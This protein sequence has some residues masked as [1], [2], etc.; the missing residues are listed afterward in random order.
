[1]KQTIL[2]EKHLQNQEKHLPRA[3]RLHEGFRQSMARSTIWATMKKFKINGKLIETIQSLYENAMSAVLVQGATGEWFHTSVGVRQGCLL[4]PNPFNSFLEDT[5][6]HALAALEV[7]RKQVSLCRFADEIDGI[8]GEEDEVTKLVH[9]LDTAPT[10][11]GME[12]NAEKP[13]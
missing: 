12:I 11:F 5:M 13:R 10:Q 7:V 1:M 8:T 4:S 2:C 9:N 6:I 3:H